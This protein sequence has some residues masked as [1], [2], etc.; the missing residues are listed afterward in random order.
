MSETPRA[1]AAWNNSS[2]GDISQLLALARQLERELAAK[3]AEVEA[4]RENLK[5]EVGVTDELLR[6]NEALRKDAERYRWLL[7]RIGATRIGGF[8][9]ADWP[10]TAADLMEG[11]V[12]GHLDAAIDAARKGK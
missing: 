9:I 11:S 6:E 12:A 4:L 2:V 10:S 5:A 1:D 3:T 7:D 8:F